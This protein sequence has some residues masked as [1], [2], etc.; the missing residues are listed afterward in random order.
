[1]VWG[2][3]ELTIVAVATG[4]TL[5]VS[6]SDNL[7]IGSVSCSMRMQVHSVIFSHIRQVLVTITPGHSHHAIVN[8]VGYHDDGT[9]TFKKKNS[10]PEPMPGKHYTR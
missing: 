6:R 2:S 5:F 7:H 10:V 1:M 4:E 8:V 9:K 3:G